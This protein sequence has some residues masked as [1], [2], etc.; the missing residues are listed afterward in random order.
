MDTISIYNARPVNRITYDNWD[1]LFT[2]LGSHFHYTTDLIYPHGLQKSI[3][4]KRISY[5]TLYC[6]IV[7]EDF[8][9]AEYAFSINDGLADMFR[10]LKK[11]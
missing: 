8:Y 10:K 9:M 2:I 1:Y 3:H 11:Y 7:F 5:N 6:D 4:P